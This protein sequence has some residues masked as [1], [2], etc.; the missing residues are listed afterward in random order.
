M[1]SYIGEGGDGF[2]MFRKYEI[3]SSTSLYDVEAIILYINKTL[4]GNIS[5]YYRKTKGR[6]IIYSNSGIE[7]HKNKSIFLLFFLIGMLSASII[8]LIN[9]IKKVKNQYFN[10][11]T[12]EIMN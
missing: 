6:I 9:F 11:L 10:N 2:S 3:I 12:E 8:F 7:K 4:N 1:N 5:D